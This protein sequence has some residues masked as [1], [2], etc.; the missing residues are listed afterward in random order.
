MAFNGIKLLNM[1]NILMKID[2]KDEEKKVFPI[3]NCLIDLR[4][5]ILIPRIEEVIYRHWSIRSDLKITNNHPDGLSE[6][7][8]ARF[9]EV[10]NSM[11]GKDCEK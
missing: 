1:P 4:Y 8:F 3:A 6:F 2:Q 10:Q 11:Y 5:M 7:Q 9:L